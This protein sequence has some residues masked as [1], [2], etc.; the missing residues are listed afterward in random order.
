MF[1]TPAMYSF[2]TTGLVQ[3]IFTCPNSTMGTPQHCVNMLSMTSLL[4]IL[5]M[6]HTLVCCLHWWHWTSKFQLRRQ[7]M[8]AF[9][10]AYNKNSFQL[11][12][13]PG[14]LS[15][16][17]VRINFIRTSIFGPFSEKWNQIAIF[18]NANKLYNFLICY[19]PIK[20]FSFYMH[21]LCLEVFDFFTL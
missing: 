11:V 6:S 7:Q 16:F 10:K 14:S 19:I 12:W 3:P 1:L 13:H 15:G 5:I 2:K 18:K 8:P 21:F 17:I 20:Y 9:K 4:L